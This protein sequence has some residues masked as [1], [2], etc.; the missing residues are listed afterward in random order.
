M[1]CWN[2]NK[3][4]KEG[5]SSFHV[6]GYT[7]LDQRFLTK[8]MPFHVRAILVYTLMTHINLS[9]VTISMDHIIGSDQHNYTE[10]IYSWPT[11]ALF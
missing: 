5:G 8:K 9:C 4:S 1:P 7:H 10:V 3:K 11:V 2:C 6:V